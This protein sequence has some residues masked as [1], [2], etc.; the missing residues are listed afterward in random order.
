MRA[1]VDLAL[2]ASTGAGGPGVARVLNK[3]NE[4]IM[5]AMERTFSRD[6]TSPNVWEDDLDLNGNA[7]FGV[8]VPYEMRKN[9]PHGEYLHEA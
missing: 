1:K 6:G 9:A 2:I 7:L 3:N 5:A 8:L 4:T